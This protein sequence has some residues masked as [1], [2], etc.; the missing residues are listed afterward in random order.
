MAERFTD[1]NLSRRQSLKIAGAGLFL[2]A[3][4]IFLP[5]TAKADIF[6]EEPRFS[7]NY[8]AQI[9][10][11]SLS[12][13]THNL[14][15]ETQLNELKTPENELEIVDFAKTAMTLP[16]N[17]HRRWVYER[18]AV[19]GCAELS[20]KT[21][22]DSGYQVTG[23]IIGALGEKYARDA[24][25][26]LIWAYRQT[27]IADD[28]PKLESKYQNWAKEN[29]TDPR[30][31]A[32][33]FD[34]QKPLSYLIA[35]DLKNRFPKMSKDQ[36]QIL[37]FQKTPDIGLLF[38]VI[39]T[40]T[41]YD[42]YYNGT[43]RT[44]ANIGEYSARKQLEQYVPEALPAYESLINR[45]SFQSGFPYNYNHGYNLPGSFMGALGPQIMPFNLHHYWQTDPA[46]HLPDANPFH[47]LGAV[48]YSG[49]YLYQ[50]GCDSTQ[51]QDL[52]KLLLQWNR[53]P[54]Q[55][56]K[57][58]GIKNSFPPPENSSNVIY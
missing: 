4:D 53:L 43:Y 8:E 17:N 55:T 12:A 40:E 57:I 48:I 15:K 5:Q 32:Y 44:L 58:L 14:A 39:S 1:K 16:I 54:K 6:Q 19:L 3:N 13:R 26:E 9:V 31:L 47:P 21:T 7:L 56:E 2:A 35:E 50:I 29:N 36:L 23:R 42:L 11:S 10:F 45:L 18:K 46:Y 24:A 33:C 34:A 52:P 27:G 22:T 37:V 30:I 20:K 25:I 49:L 41:T 28:L 51:L 38:G